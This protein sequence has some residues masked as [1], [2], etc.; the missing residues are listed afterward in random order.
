VVEHADP[1]DRVERSPLEPL[2]GLDV[3]DDDLGAVADPLACDCR[4]GL[5]QLD[6]DKFAPALEQPLR[7]LARAA[8]E[9]EAANG[10]SELRALH[11]QGGAAPGANPSGRARPA[12]HVLEV[13][14]RDRL[15]LPAFLCVALVA[16]HGSVTPGP[17]T[18][19]ATSPSAGA[20]V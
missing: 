4:S 19:S 20:I 14:L 16:H 15:A 12:P 1:H 2:A 3:A 9:L 17:P 8:A 18:I 6:G 13:A 11:Q 7:E 5:A 10:R